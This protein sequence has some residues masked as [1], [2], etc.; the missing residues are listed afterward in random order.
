MK[1]NLA[2]ILPRKIDGLFPT[3]S[4]MDSAIALMTSH[5]WQGFNLSNIN[6]EL[7]RYADDVARIARL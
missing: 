1:L 2:G 7:C 4:T 3:T 6:H 5:E